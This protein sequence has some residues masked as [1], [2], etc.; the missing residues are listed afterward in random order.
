MINRS[1]SHVII[2]FYTASLDRNIAEILPTLTSQQV[3]S[4]TQQWENAYGSYAGVVFDE[5]V[6]GPEPFQWMLRTT[7]PPILSNMKI[8][9]TDA[10]FEALIV[11]WGNLVPWSG[12]TDT[13]QKVFDAGYHLGTL[14]NGDPKTLQNAM[15][16][17]TGVKFSYYFSSDFPVGTFKPDHAM[18]DQLP[19]IS[20]YAVEEILHVA[21]ASSD[22]WGA[23]S[24]GLYSAL[25]GSP[26][27]PKQPYPCFLLKDITQL[28][29]VLGI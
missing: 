9:V 11:C 20:T 5:S 23:R 26:P 18:Y 16:I 1:L 12:T 17:F 2:F 4:L 13:L 8:T 27:Y 19:R 28:T 21:G 29:T 6:T 10:Q 3:H 24:A 15:S 25:S 7:L 14:S 22:G